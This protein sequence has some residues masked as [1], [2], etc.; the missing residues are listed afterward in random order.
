M[1]INISKIFIGY[2]E[3]KKLFNMTNIAFQEELS[4]AYSLK[5]SDLSPTFIKESYK[6]TDYRELY[7]VA[8]DNLD[9]NLLLEDG[10]LIQLGYASNK[11]E[12]IVDLRY[13]YYESPSEV[14]T[15]QEFLKEIGLN[16]TQIEECGSSFL[17]DYHQYI[18]EGTLKNHV[19][20]VRYDFSMTQYEELVHPVSHIHIGQNNEIRIPVSFIM[21]PS[22]FIAFILRHIYWE[23]WVQAIQYDDNF[24][25]HYLKSYKT[26]PKLATELHT[27]EEKFDLHFSCS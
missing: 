14:A 7:K 4:K 3:G 15:Y 11:Q 5:K 8:R 24:K 12:Q 22:N 2:E 18:S 20:N 17:D 19:T 10:S 13:A 16:P 27:M 21:T 26:E 1:S 6:G 9:Y 23:K 25:N